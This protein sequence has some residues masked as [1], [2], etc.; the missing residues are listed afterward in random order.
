MVILLQSI[1]VYSTGSSTSY[2]IYIV[3]I[4]HFCF[5]LGHAM[6][7]FTLLTAYLSTWGPPWGPMSFAPL[8]MC[9]R[10]DRGYHNLLKTISFWPFFQVD[11]STEWPKRDINF[12]DNWL[13]LLPFWPKLWSEK[14]AIWIHVH[15]CFVK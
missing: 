3:S 14:S 5:L 1:L 12:R 15:W 9:S 7:P 8:A 6:E 13:I 4:L 11:F 10:I 2:S